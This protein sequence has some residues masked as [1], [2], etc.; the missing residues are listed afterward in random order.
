M[1]SEMRHFYS[2]SDLDLETLRHLLE[3]GDWH[4]TK[5]QSGDR[6]AESLKGQTLVAVFFD[7]SL[8]TRTSFQLAVAEL[9]GQIVTLEAGAGLWNL[10]SEENVVMDGSA[11][12]HIKDAARVLGRYGQALAVRA[13]PKGND[14]SITRSDNTLNSFCRWAGVPVINMESALYHPCQAMADLMTLRERLGNLQGRRIVCTWAPHPKP[15]PTAVPNSFTLAASR[16]G[17]DLTLA[18]PEGYDLDPDILARIRTQTESSGGQFQIERDQQKALEGAQ[19]VYVKSWGSLDHYGQP[20]AESHLRSQYTDWTIDEK[21]LGSTENAFVMHCLPV[22]RGVV[23]G[24][25]VLDGP[26][27]AVYDQAENRLHAQKAILEW[28]YRKS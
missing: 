1:T 21:R 5:R 19:A 15:L 10:E 14:W 18:C 13:F 6:S 17:V 23:L 24:D 12:E 4:K 25:D 28:V 8:R 20:D 2:T 11:A 27:A 26:R 9:G 22:R 3:R 7:P 16:F